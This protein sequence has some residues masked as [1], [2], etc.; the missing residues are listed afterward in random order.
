MTR[1]PSPAGGGGPV[2]SLTFDLDTSSPHAWADLTV[3]AERGDAPSDASRLSLVRRVGLV[4][5]LVQ[6]IA[7]MIWSAFQY[8]R[9]VQSSDFVGYE[10]A[11]FLIAHGH[12]NPWVTDWK[13]YFFT[14]HAEVVIWLL[15]PLWWIWHQGVTLLW[16]Q[17]L[18]IVVTEAT[19][20]LWIVEIAAKRSGDDLADS[21]G[22][23][24]R[25]QS[26]FPHFWHR[27]MS[28]VIVASAGLVILVANPWIYWAAS[29]DFH[30]EALGACFALLSAYDLAHGRRRAWVWVALT[31]M[32]GDVAA[33]YVIGVGLSAVV[34]GRATRRA[35]VAILVVGGALVL[36]LTEIGVNTG[37]NL[38]NYLPQGA[39]SEPSARAH[40]VGNI[41]Y[42]VFTKPLSFVRA[43]WHNALNI[44]ANLAPG[45]AIGLAASWGFGVPVVVLLTNNLT[46]GFSI[47]AA[48]NIPMFCF[49]ALGTIM[50]VTRIVRR[51]PAVAWV[52]V[53]V[54][55][56]NAVGWSVVWLPRTKSQWVRVSSGAAQVLT[57]AAERIPP[58]DEVVAPQ[59][60]SGSLAERPIFETEAS[61]VPILAN[62]VW[63][64]V[65][66]DQSI[67]TQSVANALD[68]IGYLSAHAELV[69]FG[70]GV[71]I[72]RYTSNPGQREFHFPRLPLSSI[73]VPA[74]EVSGS[75]GEPVTL[76]T[77]AY[78]HVAATGEPGYVVS[79]DYWR[80][81]PG[82][83][84][85][86]V[87]LAST[88]SVNIEVWDTT[89][90]K[91]LSRQ[92]VTATS[93]ET[94]VSSPVVVLA[95]TPGQRSYKGDGIFRIA[96][97]PAPLGD[98]LEVRVWTP[99]G[100]VVTVYSI[101]LQQ[102]NSRF[103]LV[104]P[105]TGAT[106]AS[107]IGLG[108]HNGAI[109]SVTYHGARYNIYATT[110]GETVME[111]AQAL[112]PNDPAA[113]ELIIREQN[114]QLSDITGGSLISVPNH[115]GQPVLPATKY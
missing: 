33:T 73:T 63:F 90:G 49:I 30:A 34:A 82:V 106:F 115:L 15:A 68:E 66:P 20:F 32:C 94:R 39:S 101:E 12:L 113:G 85:A 9:F 81:G 105:A 43:F 56:A 41:L 92:T 10:Q 46:T 13:K 107:P 104:N 97:F 89:T 28:P 44:Y 78:W 14:S 62:H 108:A 21:G 53:F 51:F 57:V 24:Y 23:R 70:S 54:L 61:N 19:A 17:D 99:G 35:G 75:A 74:W 111:I 1:V 6:L 95:D 38:A 16:V 59:G 36:L 67:E 77:N 86:R 22:H 102:A 27:P 37:A 109:G 25:R 80:V 83:Y 42:A 58:G 48:Q 96:P 72:F 98:N 8:H 69:G 60:I 71:W 91:L 29:F 26:D 100:E 64:I 3:A 4:V 88:G 31:L 40:G 84:Q 11:W 5:L 103:G 47:T 110:S 76:G 50:L 65:A 93:G 45:G 112:Y 7:L 2:Q 18:A 55:V 52:L 114:P 79:G 87:I